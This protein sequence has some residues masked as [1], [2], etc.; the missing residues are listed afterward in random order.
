MVKNQADQVT[1]ELNDVLKQ[2]GSTAGTCSPQK[3]RVRRDLLSDL[4]RLVTQAICDA[5]EVTGKITQAT[6]GLTQD[7]INNLINDVEA[8]TSEIATLAKTLPGTIGEDA[9]EDEDQTT[10][11]P[12]STT[13]SSSSSCSASNAYDE[14]I[15]CSSTII[16]RIVTTISTTTCETV[17]RIISGC[18]LE[19]T[20]TSTFVSSSTPAC[21]VVS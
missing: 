10:T 21:Y 6:E 12:S 19:P 2:T 13:S 18:S 7:E 11:T 14:Y 5:A 8:V 16:D 4:V 20:T 1:E 9:K 3:R 15:T 17:T